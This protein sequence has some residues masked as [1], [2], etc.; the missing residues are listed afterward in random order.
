MSDEQQHSYTPEQLRTIDEQA[1]LLLSDEALGLL[2]RQACGACAASRRERAR[3]QHALAIVTARAPLLHDIVITA[4]RTAWTERLQRLPQS[5][6]ADLTIA[7]VA[8]LPD[9]LRWPYQ[10]EEEP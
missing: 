10:E 1:R 9:A 4:I 2:V 3:A 5:P 6:D 7:S 8:D